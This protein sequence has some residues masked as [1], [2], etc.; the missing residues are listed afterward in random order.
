MLA[1][2][3]VLYA[4]RDEVV[5]AANQDLAQH[6]IA[7]RDRLDP[8]AG[9]ESSDLRRPATGEM[10]DPDRGIDDDHGKRDR[11]IFL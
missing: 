6:E 10:I 1:A 9:I 8:E 2:K 4:A 5:P 11:R 7:D 3:S